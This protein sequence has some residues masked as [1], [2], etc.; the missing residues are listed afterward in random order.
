MIDRDALWHSSTKTAEWGCRSLALWSKTRLSTA[1]RDTILKAVL[2]MLL[3]PL[4]Y[5]ISVAILL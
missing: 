5:G 4:N 2:G 1:N 3:K